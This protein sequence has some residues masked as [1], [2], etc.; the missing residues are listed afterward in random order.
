MKHDTEKLSD[1]LMETLSE[2]DKSQ[3]KTVTWN[4]NEKK[5]LKIQKS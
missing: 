1:I 5:V 4:M 3:A 2:M